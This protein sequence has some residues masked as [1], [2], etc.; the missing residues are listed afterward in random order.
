MY[1]IRLTAETNIWATNGK[2]C[3]SHLSP[4]RQETL[5]PGSSG[6]AACLTCRDTSALSLVTLLPSAVQTEKKQWP[7]SQCPF[8]LSSTRL[9]HSGATTAEAQRR[10]LPGSR[11]KQT[12][13]LGRPVCLSPAH[14]AK[15]SAAWLQVANSVKKEKGS[16]E[17][18]NND[19]KCLLGC[20]ETVTALSA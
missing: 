1:L 12:S 18:E 7:R 9:L 17:E 2:V 19:L 10:P 6:G 14:S 3:S 16:W 20:W 15:Q 11:E 4:E 13:Q 5:H 8:F